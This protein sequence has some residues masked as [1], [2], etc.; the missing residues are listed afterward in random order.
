MKP[1]GSS[2]GGIAYN[3]IYETIEFLNLNE[4]NHVLINWIRGKINHKPL[5]SSFGG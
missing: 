4:M 5:G 2:F 3:L 1:L